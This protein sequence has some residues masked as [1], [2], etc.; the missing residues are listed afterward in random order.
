MLFVRQDTHCHAHCQ[1]NLVTRT[2]NRIKTL[3]GIQQGS[4][5]P[6]QLN[7]AN[8]QRWILKRAGLT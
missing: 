4:N 7:S 2:K 3:S 6:P 8:K 5:I 1:K